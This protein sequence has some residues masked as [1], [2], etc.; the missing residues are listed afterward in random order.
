MPSS[1][2]NIFSINFKTHTHGVQRRMVLVDNFFDF[3]ELIF[4]AYL[5]LHVT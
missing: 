1:T 2:V 3:L 5:L 4:F